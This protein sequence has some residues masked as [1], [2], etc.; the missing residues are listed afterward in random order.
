MLNKLTKLENP[1]IVEKLTMLEKLCADKIFILGNLITRVKNTHNIL[2]PWINCI[3][4][5]II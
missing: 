2:K 5:K 3:F 4:L 1:T